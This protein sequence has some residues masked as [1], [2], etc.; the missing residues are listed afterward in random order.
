MK[1]LIAL[2]LTLVMV[3]GMTACGNAAYANENINT[4]SALTNIHPE[5][6][7]ASDY[8]GEAYIVVN[9]NVPF[10]SE[11]EKDCTDC[12]EEYSE[13]DY[14]GR[15]GV[16]YANICQE[17]MPTEGRESLRSVT[18][19]GWHQKEYDF[20]DGRAVYNRSHII[21]FQLAGE[22]A[23]EKNLLAGTRYMN[24]E[25]IPFENMV[26]DYVKEEDGHVLYRVTPIFHGDNLLCEG[27]LMEG[28][29]VED[30]G[31]AICFN[32]FLFNVQPGVEFDYATGENWLADDNSADLHLFILNTN[33]H[34]F[35]RPSCDSVA[36][37]ANRNKEE[38][39]GTRNELLDM[40]YKPCGGCNP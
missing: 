35:H 30:D 12:F 9:G 7:S 2:M 18:P 20:V 40:G 6:F 8:D 26:A 11:M 13:L 33:T 25:M 1:K 15:C 31:E 36:D 29:S 5:A 21:G 14:L 16:A 39:H 28:W 23:N 37:I 4:P 17:L 38:F 34:K 19:S 22:Q 10:F 32:V 3:L 27:V 24:V